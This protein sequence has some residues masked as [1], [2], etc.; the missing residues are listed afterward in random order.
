MQLNSLTKNEKQVAI[1]S[2]IMAC[3]LL[4]WHIHGFFPKRVAKNIEIDEAVGQQIPLPPKFSRITFFHSAKPICTLAI[5]E[6][7][8]GKYRLRDNGSEA[9]FLYIQEEGDPEL[10]YIKKYKKNGKMDEV[11]E[12]KILETKSNVYVAGLST[13]GVDKFVHKDEFE[14]M[15]KELAEVLNNFRCF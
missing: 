11:N 7:W 12:K 8:E 13:Q 10:F 1:I 14:K 2:I 4:V 15:T 6:A 3:F 9:H 5:P